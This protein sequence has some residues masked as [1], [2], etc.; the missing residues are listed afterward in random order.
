MGR[1]YLKGLD[2]AMNVN[3]SIDGS[4]LTT[5][6]S[7]FIALSFAFSSCQLIFDV[8]N[9]I[10]WEMFQMRPVI[11]WLTIVFGMAVAFFAVALEAKAQSH[12]GFIYGK[13]YTENTTYTGPIR[14]GNE[15]V[16]WTDIFNASKAGDQF[17][18]LVPQ[19]DKEDDSWLNIDWSFGSIWENKI[20]A[21]QFGTQFGNIAEMTMLRDSKVSLKLKNGR[22]YILSG[23]G[24]NDIGSKIQVVDSELG[25]IGVNWEKIRKIEFLPTPQKLDAIFGAPLY[26]TVEGTR[27]EKFT[28]FIIWDNDERLGV[29]KLD[30]DSEDGNVSLRFSDINKIEKHGSGCQVTL[31]SG[32]QI[33]LH[34]SNDVNDS[35]R[36]VLVV[37][38]EL[39]VV[40]YKWEAFRS[41]TFSTGNN[42]GPS[43]ESFAKPN[44]LSGIVSSLDG[45]EYSGQ[46]VYDIDEMFDIEILEGIENDIEYGVIFKNIRKIIPKNED[47]SSITLRNGQSLLLGNGQDVSNRNGGVLIFEKGKKEPRYVSWRKINEIT[48]N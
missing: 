9:R 3:F 35:N 38:P 20:I 31:R 1:S 4:R 28:G 42:S 10:L 34:N 48:F 25:V 40:K 45:E 15:E 2:R 7:R 18:K 26:G 12:E 32:R 6:N 8:S 5:R 23:Q 27:H 44:Q 41:V 43:F 21:H 16:F 46:I 39:G 30:G 29:D 17:K 14:W 47:Y 13:V 24:Y 33:S 11:K 22:E 36:G 37:V 19:K